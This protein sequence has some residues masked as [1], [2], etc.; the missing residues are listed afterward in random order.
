MVCRA[1]CEK[2]VSGFSGAK[3][4]GCNN[5]SDVYDYVVRTIP[6]NFANFN[7]T[8]PPS[9]VTLRSPVL[10]HLPAAPSSPLSLSYSV[11]PST[12]PTVDTSSSS[13]SSFASSSSSAFAKLEA[14]LAERVPASHSCS[15]TSCR[16]TIRHLE[17]Q[18]AA[19][20]GVASA[21]IRESDQRHS[22]STLRIKSLETQVQAAHSF[23]SVLQEHVRSLEALTH[24]L[25]LNLNNGKSRL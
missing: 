17:R 6:D 8:F 24:Y 22:A 1:E 21:L 14:V 16:A 23:N 19:T 15:C 13:S 20:D 10:A 12:D 5:E 25:E 9:D 18:I 7:F 2:Q 11:I 3:Y 4:K